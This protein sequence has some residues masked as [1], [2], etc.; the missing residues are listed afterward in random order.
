MN[1]ALEAVLITMLNRR[2]IGGR[3]TNEEQLI[4]AKT[5]WCVERSGF[6]S[7]YKTLINEGYIIKLKKRTGKGSD[8]HI[9]LN[10]RKLRELKQ[11][12]ES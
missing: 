3:H 7:E 11:L 2:Y 4:K 6:E 12:L 5:R 9:S 10:P 8:W 1:R